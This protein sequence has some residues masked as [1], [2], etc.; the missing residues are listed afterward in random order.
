MRK[1]WWNLLLVA[2]LCLNLGFVAAIAAHSLRSRHHEPR[3]D[4]AAADPAVRAKLEA[5]FTAFKARMAPLHQELAA[6]R[7]KLMDLVESDNATPDQIKS[8]EERVVA[9][10]A[11]AL[12]TATQHL[13]SQ[14]KL[15]TPQES[16]IFFSRIRHHVQPGGSDP[17]HSKERS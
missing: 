6:E 15:L 8:Q 4:E 9:V 1:R 3:P 7:G 11:K 14:K 16:K 2:S 13:L 12:D 5:N 17:T 10:M